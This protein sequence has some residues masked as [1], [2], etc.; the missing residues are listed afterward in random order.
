MN[1]LTPTKR[2]TFASL[3]IG[4]LK[5]SIGLLQMKNPINT[6]FTR[7]SRDDNSSDLV[8]TTKENT[9]IQKHIAL[10]NIQKAIDKVEEIKKETECDLKINYTLAKE[11]VTEKDVFCS[12]QANRIGKYQ[13][14]YN[15]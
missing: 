6:L 10:S 5:Q 8:D 9:N 4:P 14:I 3:P 11:R 1:E 15:E 7:N 13:T 12:L 2:K